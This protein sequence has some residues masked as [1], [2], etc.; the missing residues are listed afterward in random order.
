ML[1]SLKK[2][3]FKAA[4]LIIKAV[5]FLN[6]DYAGCRKLFHRLLICYTKNIMT[7]L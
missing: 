5:V 2:R 3:S 4:A 6:K 7:I 1:T